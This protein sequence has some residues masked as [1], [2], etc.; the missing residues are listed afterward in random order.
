MFAVDSTFLLF[1][2]GLAI[3]FKNSESWETQIW[4]Y[5]LLFKVRVRVRSCGAGVCMARAVMSTLWN[6]EGIRHC[7]QSEGYLP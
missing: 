6:S 2:V 4:L 5:W 7:G 1:L 3:S